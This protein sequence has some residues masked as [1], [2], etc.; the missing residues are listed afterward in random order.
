MMKLPI[1]QSDSHQLPAMTEANKGLR[2]ERFFDKYQL[3]SSDIKPKDDAKKS[4]LAAFANITCGNRQAIEQ[5]KLR[6]WSLAKSQKGDGK[7]YQLD[8][9]FVTGMGNSHPVENGFLWHYTLGTPYLSGS[10]VKGLV[11]AL[12]EQYYQG[13]DKADLL[14]QWFG[15]DAKDPKK[16]SRDSQAGELIF[17]DAIPTSPPTL[18]VDIMTPHMGDWYAKGADIKNAKNDSDKI[19]ADWHDPTPIPFLAVKNANFLFSIGKRPHSKIDIKEVFACLDNALQYLGAGAKTQTG[20]GYM[21]FVKKAT[22]DLQETVEQQ[23][24]QAKEDADLEKAKSNASPL[25]AELLDCIK[26]NNWRDNNDTAK[27]SF[28]NMLKATWLERLEANQEDKACIQC[29][30]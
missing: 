1:Y 28:T 12:I 9:H 22:D 23:Q 17:F 19:P 10:M 26:Q 6:Q 5:T 4:F 16:A 25:H 7:I 20:Y 15:S 24:Q 11:R 18:S 27:Q 14:Y 3:T 13:E 30:L 8:G 29:M 2:F 21:S